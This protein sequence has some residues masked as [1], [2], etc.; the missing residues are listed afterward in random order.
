MINVPLSNILYTGRLDYRKGLTD[1]IKSAKFVLN[2]YPDVSFLLAGDGN[3]RPNLERLVKKEGLEK[4]F[5]F[6][7]YINQEKLIEHYQ[8]DTINV[9]PSYM[10]GLPTTVLEAMACEMPVVATDV[11]GTNEAV[12]DSINGI[13]IPPKNPEKLANA[14]LKL[15]NDENLRRNMG[16]NGRNYIERKFTWDKIAKNIVRSYNEAV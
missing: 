9:L 4:N 1:L 16:K 15:L 14:L 5:S 2:E 8:R 12:I 13:L 11:S 6:L 3:L 10:E 7:G